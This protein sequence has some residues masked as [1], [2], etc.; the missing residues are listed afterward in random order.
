MSRKKSKRTF[1][2]KYLLL[3]FVLCFLLIL[4]LIFT[5]IKTFFVNNETY[6]V[7]NSRVEKIKENRKKDADDYRTIG[8]IQVQGTNI[9]APILKG[10]DRTFNYPVE[11]ENYGWTV[12]VDDTYHN[13]VT[14]FGHNIFNLGP[15]PKLS[16]DNFKRFEELMNFVYYD[17]AK[18]N[19]YIQLTMENKEYVYKIYAVSFLYSYEVNAFPQGDYTKTEMTDHIKKL[20]ENSIYDYDIDVNTSDN[21]ISVVTCT[22]FLGTDAYRNI[23]ISGRLVR[24]K[25]KYN[26]YSVKK[27][28][29]YKKIEEVLKGDGNDEKIGSA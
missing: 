29:N 25:E 21:L 14:V 9:D 19:K 7:S 26:D 28:G 12:N 4:F 5:L 10:V 2:R 17:F 22:R 16:S 23:L 11:L 24:E 27:N 6:Y 13:S 1:F 20:K 3:L 18:E 8:W 15:S